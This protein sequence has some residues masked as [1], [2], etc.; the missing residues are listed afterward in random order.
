[1]L[2]PQNRAPKYLKLLPYPRID[3]VY[4]YTTTFVKCLCFVSDFIIIM[5][6]PF[7]FSEKYC[8]TSV[9]VGLNASERMMTVSCS[10]LLICLSRVYNEKQSRN[11]KIKTNH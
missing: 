10:M 4:N 2:N 6:I 9:V 7:W 11:S 5:M 3:R 8:R 1:M